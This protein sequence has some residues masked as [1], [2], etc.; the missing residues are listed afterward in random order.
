MR[1]A[2]VDVDPSA[3]APR[4]GRSAVHGERLAGDEIGGVEL[5]E[6]RQRVAEDGKHRGVV[7]HRPRSVR[8][9]ETSGAFLLRASCVK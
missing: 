3:A 8:Q 5:P 2:L 1:I 7:A 4:P 9:F 6:Q